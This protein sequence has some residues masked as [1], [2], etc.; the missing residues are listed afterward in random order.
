M[1]IILEREF[2]REGGLKAH[3]RRYSRE[4]KVKRYITSGGRTILH[5]QSEDIL[6]SN[7][8]GILEKLDPAIWLKPLLTNHFDSHTFPE[9]LS[10]VNYDREK[11]KFYFWHEL[12]S[13][14]RP[15]GHEEGSTQVDLLIEMPESVI[16]F[17]IKLS[18]EISPEITSDKK[19]PMKNRL[20]VPNPSLRW[21]QI[22]RNLERGYIYTR[23]KFPGKKFLLFILAMEKE[24]EK[25]PFYS[26]YK[27]NPTEVQKQIESG[28]RWEEADIH[29]YFSE[30]IYQTL[31]K[32]L[33]WM[34]WGTFNEILE[35]V[36][37]QTKVENDFKEEVVNYIRN[38]INL[39]NEVKMVGIGN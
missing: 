21:D 5:R 39:H 3:G 28:Y 35:K 14:K 12:G 38:K 31:S 30:S 7:V 34:T 17:E 6:T 37:F 15:K 25:T 16:S 24:S 8:F 29:Q 20:G 13:P 26:R 27:N 10:D 22:I 11:I 18:A 19:D 4:G 1:T 33:A 36:I 32:S 23:N 9:L 2:E